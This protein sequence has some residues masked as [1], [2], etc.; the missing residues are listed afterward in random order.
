M[1]KTKIDW[2]D[3]TVNPV[4]GLCPVNCKDKQGKS[5]CYA[6]SMYKRYKWNP[7]IRFD[8]S[9]LDW[10]PPKGS[11]VFIGST[12][13]LFGSWVKE[14]WMNHIMAWAQ[15]NKETTF[16]FL[17]KQPHNLA[18]WSPFPD[19]CW[20]GVSVCNDK[21]LDVAV[22]KLE[23]TQAKVKFIS[24]EPLLEHLTLSF[25]YAFYYSGISWIIIGQQTPVS[26]KTEPK[27]E[28]VREIVEA[29]DRAGIPVFLKDN[30]ESVFC[31]KDFKDHIYFP[32]WATARGVYRQEFPIINK[33]EE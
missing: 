25:D 4:K 32:S 33:K 1:N 5:Y 9:F 22:D 15:M 6:R 16:I 31:V 18:K 20:V 17:T 26:K 7:E 19:N 12:M 30:L 2:A 8:D 21:M 27:I 29:A 13:E 24:F 11:K 23:D 28:W 10:R 3:F 14:D